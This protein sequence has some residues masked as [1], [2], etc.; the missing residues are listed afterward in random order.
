MYFVFMYENRRMKLKIVLTRR[1]GEE[2]E[3]WRWLL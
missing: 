3:Q 1:E 2:G